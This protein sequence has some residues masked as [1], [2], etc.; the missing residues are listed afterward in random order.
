MSRKTL[1]LSAFGSLGKT[2]TTPC[3]VPTNTRLE[4]SPA[5][6]SS[7]GRN[8]TCL[9]VGVSPFQPVHFMSGKAIAV[10]IGKGD[11]STSQPG[12]AAGSFVSVPALPSTTY[13]N[14]PA[15]STQTLVATSGAAVNAIGLMP[16]RGMPHT[17][18]W[19]ATYIRPNWSHA[20]FALPVKPSAI[21][22]VIPSLRRTRCTSPEKKSWQT[23]KEAPSVTNAHGDLISF[24]LAIPATG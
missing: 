11:M 10:L 16:G 17:L 14:S 9:P 6:V 22:L 8:S 24:D 3:C 13:K 23:T 18:P 5:W 2:W 19:P 20:M 7:R 4:P 12:I 1:D 21:L 15:G